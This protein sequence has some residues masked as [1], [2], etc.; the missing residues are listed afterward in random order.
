MA[1]RAGDPRTDDTRQRLLD[2]AT[3]VF[4]EV[5]YDGARVQEIA[6]RAGLTTGA[7]YGKFRDKAELLVEA[8]GALGRRPAHRDGHRPDARLGVGPPGPAH[9]GP[10][11]GAPRPRPGRPRPQGRP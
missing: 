11:R 7:I 4:A 6:R 5:G 9:R 1:L 2:A 3:Q 10:R 8:I